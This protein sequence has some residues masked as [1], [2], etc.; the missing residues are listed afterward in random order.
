M[1]VSDIIPSKSYLET[2]VRRKTLE[3]RQQ[4][5]LSKIKDLI[6]TAYREGQPTVE[7]KVNDWCYDSDKLKKELKELGY[8]VSLM[9]ERSDYDGTKVPVS[10]T[11]IML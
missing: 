9:K 5:Y 3:D 1:K 2:N 8:A 4:E 11:I 10:M 7:F 6:E